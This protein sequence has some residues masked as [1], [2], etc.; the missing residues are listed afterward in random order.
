MIRIAL[1]A[2]ALS[3]TSQTDACSLRPERAA[4]KADQRYNRV[5]GLVRKDLLSLVWGFADKYYKGS[6]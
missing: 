3:K 5:I 1:Y 6:Q 2:V 4:V